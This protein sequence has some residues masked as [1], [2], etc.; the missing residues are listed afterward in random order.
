MTLRIDI[1]ALRER[2]IER[3]RQQTDRA[4]AL[5]AHGVALLTDKP[6]HTSSKMIPSR[7]RVLP[8]RRRGD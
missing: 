3:T 4:A 5:R 7:A 2:L 1:D 8:W 6:R